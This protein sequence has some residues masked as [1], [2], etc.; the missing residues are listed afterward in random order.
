MAH[1]IASSPPPAR[2][3]DDGRSTSRTKHPLARAATF[4]ALSQ[5]LM[6]TGTGR[7]CRHDLDRL[8]PGSG[9]IYDRLY[10]NPASREAG[11]GNR[12]AGRT[13]PCR[14]FTD[15]AGYA[16]PA[17]RTRSWWICPVT[18]PTVA[19]VKRS[20]SAPCR[21]ARLL[22]DACAQPCQVRMPR[23]N[24]PPVL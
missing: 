18:A 8:W 20:D 5:L 13:G 3:P 15:T 6:Q 16:G 14:R 23:K 10:C 9:R 4:R 12:A 22:A 1:E 11:T 17:L 24:P 21:T 7:C 19:E 2:G